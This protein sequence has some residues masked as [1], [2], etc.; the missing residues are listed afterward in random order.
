[1]VESIQLP[2]SW[3]Q[4]SSLDGA[5]K[6]RRICPLVMSLCN[7]VRKRGGVESPV[8][9]LS[10]WQM[11]N[12]QLR[13]RFMEFQVTDRSG[14]SGYWSDER[15]LNRLN[16]AEGCRHLMTANLNFLVLWVTSVPQKLN[17][18]IENS[19]KMS[20]AEIDDKIYVD[21]RDNRLEMVSSVN[22]SFVYWIKLSDRQSSLREGL[23]N[24][25]CQAKQWWNV[26]INM[27]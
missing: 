22:L 10:V 9:H 13:A 2:N 27:A 5:V 21:F 8:D 24:S 20:S 4:G 18:S 11:D 14:G 6:P 17:T 15:K 26:S 7:D 12:G 1:M 3:L 19:E 25:F 16:N 23:Q